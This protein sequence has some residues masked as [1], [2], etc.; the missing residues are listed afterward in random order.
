MCKP[1]KSLRNQRSTCPA[2]GDAAPRCAAEK[3][4]KGHGRA[5][6]P[7]DADRGVRDEGNGERSVRSCGSPWGRGA[8]EGAAL[9]D[10]MLD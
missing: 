9:G 6:G 2:R 4:E 10:E 1:L 5:R 8:A 3:G 7:G